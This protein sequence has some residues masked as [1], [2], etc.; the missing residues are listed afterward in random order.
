M[1][2]SH[3]PVYWVQ[4]YEVVE[5]RDNPIRGGGGKANTRDFQDKITPGEVKASNYCIT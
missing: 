2:R 4:R 3:T 1:R 5:S